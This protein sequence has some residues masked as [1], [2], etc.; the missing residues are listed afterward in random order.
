MY[1]LGASSKVGLDLSPAL[2]GTLYKCFSAAQTTAVVELGVN[3][4]SRPGSDFTESEGFHLPFI[5]SP[6]IASLD[7]CTPESSQLAP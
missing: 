2:N 6:V 1:R 4:A 3:E 7:M 5:T